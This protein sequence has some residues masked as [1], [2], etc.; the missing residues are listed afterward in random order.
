[1]LRFVEPAARVLAA[2]FAL[3]A[4]VA[5]APYAETSRRQPHPVGDLLVG[6][7]VAPASVNSARTVS[8]IAHARIAAPPQ[9]K[10]P[11]LVA[12]APELGARGH[13]PRVMVAAYG[14]SGSGVIGELGARSPG[15]PGKI[16]WAPV[17][18]VPKPLSATTPAMAAA[19]TARPS[20]V[21]EAMPVLSTLAERMG[22][23]GLGAQLME[24]TLLFAKRKR[25]EPGR[26]PMSRSPGLDH[27]YSHAGD[28]LAVLQFDDAPA[29]EFIMPFA[30]GRVT[31]L[32][33]QGRVHPAIDLAGKLGSP[34]LATTSRQKVVFAGPRG[35]YGNAVITAD[36][37]G[38][39]HLYGH[40]QRITSRVGQLLDQGDKLGHL[41]STGHSTGPHVHYEVRNSKGTHINPVT[42]L[43]PGRGVAKGYAWLNVRQE[44][45]V[46]RVAARTR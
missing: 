37:F 27:V 18:A 16:S 35:G 31:S 28:P 30:S 21:E 22:A 20:H 11:Q 41:G 45:V 10:L 26:L 23:Q 42:L 14:P 7:R 40:L 5:A 13:G 17:P 9:G 32:F 2:G 34:V 46:A 3:A 43:F 39:T 1:M 6:A 19:S 25:S 36:P 4:G 44:S 38:R 12:D 29:P 8:R 33:N 15:Q 24:D